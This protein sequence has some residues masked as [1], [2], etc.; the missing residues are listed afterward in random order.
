MRR[1]RS[2]WLAGRRVSGPLLLVVLALL[3]FPA[4]GSDDSYITYWA[5]H[6]LA[7]TGEI[8]S[9]NGERLEQSSS[10][11]H[12]LV[13]AAGARLTG[14]TVPAVGA[15][16][17]PLGSA[18]TLVGT[19]A[20]ARRVRPKAAFLAGLLA[21][22]SSYLLFWTFGGLETTLA[23]A[24]LTCALVACVD[25]TSGTPSRR[26]WLLALASVLAT[27]LV[28]PEGG[29]VLGAALAGA[30][31][32][33]HRQARAGSGVDRVD[34]SEGS[35]PRT[36]ARRLA[37]LVAIVVVASA[38]LVLARL[39]YFGAPFPNPVVAKTGGPPSADGWLYLVQLWV[40]RY[41]VPILIA[42]GAGGVLL[43]ARVR[44]AAGSLVCSALTAVTGF[45]LLS[46]GDW[47]QGG[48]FL[49]AAVPL[50][51]VLAAVAI[52]AIPSTTWRRSLAGGLVVCQV[53][54]IADLA[55]QRSTTTPLWADA[56]FALATADED[57]FGWYELRNRV[58]LRNAAALVEAED[59]IDRVA[60]ITPA[61]AP[62][63]IAGV[64]AGFTLYYLFESSGG[65]LRFIDRHNLVS[66][67]FTSCEQLLRPSD[68]GLGRAMT[69]DDWFAN[70]DTCQVP[71]PDAVIEYGALE[72]QPA[73]IGRYTTVAH[74]EQQTN[75][76][77]GRAPGFDV[78][79]A[80]FV[81]VRNDLITA[82]RQDEAPIP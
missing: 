63:T 56:T 53:L 3:V 77:D 33:Q 4:G 45:V 41:Q 5:A 2:P 34:P 70:I 67:V 39:A 7:E 35:G 16:V 78:G 62:I 12:T 60:R 73:L 49:V 32:L 13:L 22:T 59:V 54:G 21:S 50:I 66:D 42:A 17:A 26:R 10:L 23:S 25:V 72:D 38:A 80:Q 47:M 65:R 44:S 40:T 58:H 74:V 48:R 71:M 18:V 69:Y 14:S 28:R 52:T 51:A 20:L 19:V 24:A 36:A 11:L 37:L 43:L 8:L 1:E 61:P 82:Y 75:E 55:V 15:L 68:R 27:V 76:A 30:T 79:T 81:A 6:S 9:Y 29:L 57:R 64:Q 46:G 31:C